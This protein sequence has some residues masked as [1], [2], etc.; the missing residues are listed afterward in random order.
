MELISSWILFQSHVLWLLI[1]HNA[2]LCICFRPTAF[3][4]T[5]RTFVFLLV[6]FNNL[7]S[8]AYPSTWC[9][10]FSINLSFFSSMF[11]MSYSGIKVKNTGKMHFLVSRIYRIGNLW[12][13][14]CNWQYSI[15]PTP[16]HKKGI[17]FLS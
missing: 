13:N 15:P 12:T 11:L 16:S 8:S 6:V 1:H 4:M 17:F 10:L 9:V 7:T 5:I 3:L 2:F 14:F